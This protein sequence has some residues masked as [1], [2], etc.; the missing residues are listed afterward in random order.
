MYTTNGG[1]EIIYPFLSF[2][3]GY[4]VFTLTI[5]AIVA[6]I[7]T[8]IPLWA[9]FKKAGVKG[10]KAIVPI[11]NI[12]IIYKICW[13]PEIFWAAI[14]VALITSVSGIFAILS[15]GS[16]VIGF[17]LAICVISQVLSIFLAI[18]LCIFIS[19]SYGHSYG[20]AIGFVLLP[21]I[22]SYIVAF[23]G[24]KYVG[25]E[26]IKPATRKKVAAKSSVKKPAAK[27]KARK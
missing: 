17:H 18:Y 23:G 10:W 8:V 2:L 16:G 5:T 25:P 22:F 21:T 12:Y 3:A 27:K 7:I 20:F 1:G 9:M 11:Y 4:G 13:K 15:A 24:S 14:A 26:G 6:Y 19:K